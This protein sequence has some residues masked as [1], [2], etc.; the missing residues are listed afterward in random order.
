MKQLLMGILF[1]VMTALVPAWAQD[2]PTS[3]FVEQAT[4]TQAC[5]HKR[6]TV[7]VG[8]MFNDWRYFEPWL[9]DIRKTRSCIF[10]F[11]YS[12]TKSPML[13]GAQLLEQDLQA[14]QDAGY[15]EIVILAHSMGGLVVKKA[16]HL[17]AETP[18]SALVRVRFH[19]YGTP[20]GGFFWANFIPPAPGMD[21]VLLQMGVPMAK[22]I[23]SFSGYIESL[24]TP[25]P[26]NMSVV[27]H[28]SV[29]D[30]VAQPDSEAAKAHFA[31][32][33]ESATEVRVYSDIGHS[34]FVNRL[35]FTD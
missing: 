2:A 14:L 15:E 7:L 26:S 35:R 28:N 32:A 30:E 34:D 11:S 13:A 17:F 9:P 12:H 23:G 31:A 8:G 22:D 24:R 6:A 16:L 10:G 18:F 21:T 19:A 1:A 25:L 29:V 5:D 3:G 20:W 4:E 33:I 27:L